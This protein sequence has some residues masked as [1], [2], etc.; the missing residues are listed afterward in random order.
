MKYS[1]IMKVTVATVEKVIPQ[2]TYPAVHEMLR[3][4]I[5]QLE[6]A[7][8][9]LA[10]WMTTETGKYVCSTLEIWK[11]PLSEWQTAVKG[12]AV[13]C[14]RY[15]QVFGCGATEVEHAFAMRKLI[16]LMGRSAA[17]ADWAKEVSDRIG[18]TT[19]KR[20]Y[21]HGMVTSEAYRDIRQR[22]LNGIV[23]AAMAELI[24]RSGTF[25]E[26]M[27]ERWWATPR[28][29]SS[30]SAAVKAILKKA[31]NPTLDLQL[32]PIKP[33]TYEVDS[34]VDVLSSAACIPNAH[35]RGSTKPEPGYKCRALLAV[36]DAT[37]FIAGYA[38]Q[39]VELVAKTEGM[40]L[41]QDPADVSEWVNFDIG[42]DVWRVSNDYSNFNILNSLRSMQLVDLTFAQAWS[43]VKM[44]YAKQKELA[45]KWVAAS[46]AAASFSCPQGVYLATT[47]LWSGH[48][49]TARDNTILHVC[50]LNCIKSVMAALFKSHVRVLKQRI[51]G[52]DETLSYTKWACAAV[53]ALV[54]DALGF[55]SQVSK[56]MLSRRH[57]EFLQLIRMPGRPPKYP[58]AHTILTFCSGNWYKDPVR[59]ISSTIKDISD[60][61]WDMVLGGV[62]LLI[63]QLLG[64]RVLNY[65]IQVK[66]SDNRLVPLEWWDYRGCGLPE[67]H[68]LWG[69]D[70]T[71]AAPVL[72]TDL[73]VGD[74]PA[75]A[76]DDS[77]MREQDAWAVIE[78]AVR[79]R[80]RA[81]RLM[82][83][84]RNVAKNALTTQYDS[85]I[86]ETW[87]QRS[88]RRYVFPKVSGLPQV[89]TNRWRAIPDRLIGRS[90][91]AVAIQVKFPPELLDTPDMWRAMITLKP[92]ERAAMLLGLQQRQQPTRG[93]RWLLPPLL[94]AI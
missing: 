2:D 89:Q 50:Y 29:T 24:K 66:D 49:N 79:Q 55:T 40:V 42:A 12:F 53:H 32:R 10:I 63:A 8:A 21:K 80:V 72:A 30:R 1:E 58:V 36:D 90:A 87:P 22:S 35:A 3:W 51:C 41:R 91:R 48:R 85:K 73:S 17:D 23:K 27:M 7:V 46:Y 28:G 71:I 34:V 31:D 14:R 59:D 81:Q 61:L 26:Y 5:G 56:G 25:S 68:P 52:D 83:S 74:L 13:D 62:P 57:D 70:R 94:R 44:R 33:V 60:H 75:F 92:R 19:P 16:A 37:A 69:C 86:I 47:G 64:A 6:Y 88:P 65:L 15:G 9:A 82:Q 45:H 93:W 78:P 39:R 54:A 76:T 11:I 4:Q 20:G 84:Y 77:L 18:D 38:S 67:G 43:T